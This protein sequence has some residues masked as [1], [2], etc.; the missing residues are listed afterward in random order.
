MNTEIYVFFGF[1]WWYYEWL[2]TDTWF[3]LSLWG[4]GMGF[5]MNLVERAG[6]NLCPVVHVEEHTGRIQSACIL[7]FLSVN[8]QQVIKTYAY[9]NT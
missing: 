7:Q 1:M 4:F 9:G 5:V 6:T 8:I 3:Q 2:H